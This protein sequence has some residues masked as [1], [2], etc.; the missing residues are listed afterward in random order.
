[1]S[2]DD[3]G[4]QGA[5]T[6]AH[7]S[8]IEEIV[9][10]RLS[11]EEREDLMHSIEHI[12]TVGSH[13]RH[14]TQRT[15]EWDNSQQTQGSSQANERMMHAEDVRIYGKASGYRMSHWPA[16]VYATSQETQNDGEWDQEHGDSI[17]PLAFLE[18]RLSDMPHPK[19]QRI[20]GPNLSVDKTDCVV[21]LD[22]VPRAMLVRC[23]ERAV[24][25]AGSI[26]QCDGAIQ[27]EI[28]S[29]IQP[30]A[31][32]LVQ[33]ETEYSYENTVKKCKNLNIHLA[34]NAQAC[35]SCGADFDS[36]K[37]LRRHF[38]GSQQR[39]CCWTKIRMTQ[40]DLLDQVLQKEVSDC[41]NG[42]V[43][44]IMATLDD[45]Q[46]EQDEGGL[47]VRNWNHV[48]HVL[49]STYVSA[50]AH[51]SPCMTP[52]TLNAKVLESVRMRLVERYADMPK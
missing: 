30:D 43:R 1:M 44:M 14:T 20:D 6:V 26:I 46:M 36:S 4:S 39:G 41:G 48:I 21:A 15:N 22:E 47:V 31:T 3:E 11:R 17:Q 16:S 45:R 25:A 35:P 32:S 33:Q 29:S 42:L 52:T 28:A 49:E 51:P 13:I 12:V 18:A 19:R 5:A 24:H 37:D 9:S 34:A 38:F 27:Q 7:S 10:R 50:D 2:D 8:E 40:Y 23:W